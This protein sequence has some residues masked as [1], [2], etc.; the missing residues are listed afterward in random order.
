MVIAVAGVIVV[1]VSAT[2]EQLS[3]EFW[4]DGMVGALVKQFRIQWVIYFQ[5]SLHNPI[6]FSQSTCSSWFIWTNG[7]WLY[8]VLQL[9]GTRTAEC[10]WWD[11]RCTGC[12]RA[13]VFPLP[14]GHASPKRSRSSTSK[15]RREPK[16]FYKVG[17]VLFMEENAK[18][19][20]IIDYLIKYTENPSESGVAS[21][22]LNYSLSAA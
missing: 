13:S 3:S 19:S 14:Q 18:F 8:F 20:L 10:C 7:N 2:T 4:I 15:K 12:W 9:S 1:S 17:L 6:S 5:F 16:N 11:T 22:R 21:N